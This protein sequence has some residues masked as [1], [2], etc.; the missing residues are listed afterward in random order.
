MEYYFS[1]Q[2][3]S[4]VT[5]TDPRQAPSTVHSAIAADNLT[6]VRSY[7]FN[8]TPPGWIVTNTNLATGPWQRGTPVDPRDPSSDFDGSGQCWVTGNAT[9]VDVDGGPT[10]LT[11]EIFDLSSAA[12]PYVRYA[13]W[14]TTLTTDDD[15]LVVQASQNGG[16]SWITIESLA[17]FPGWETHGFRVRDHFTN[18]SQFRMRFAVADQPNNSVTEAA[19]DAFRRIHAFA[20]RDPGFLRIDRDG[21]EVAHH[22][23]A[24]GNQHAFGVAQY[25]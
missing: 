25:A 6:T 7:N 3:T 13:L 15:H 9:N 12:D 19:L 5:Y 21:A 11:T 20:Y 17:E 10:T 23:A 16:G 4:N 8:T 22:G 14:F 2:D 1:A 18:L 24:L